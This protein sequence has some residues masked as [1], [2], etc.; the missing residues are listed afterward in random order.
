MYDT[1]E[2]ERHLAPFLWGEFLKSRIAAAAVAVVLALGV[3]GTA[4]ASTTLP[5]TNTAHRCVH[6]TTGVCGWEAG[7]KPADRYETARCKDNSHSYSRHS[8]GTCSH[9][10]GVKYWWK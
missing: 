3:A 9:H 8:S 4:E 10:R 2:K 6:H 5:R 1:A 7:K